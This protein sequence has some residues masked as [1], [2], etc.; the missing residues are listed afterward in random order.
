MLLRVLG[1]VQHRHSRKRS[2]VRDV[3]FGQDPFGRHPCCRSYAYDE[4]GIVA[5]R[6]SSQHLER[7]ESSRALSSG[8]NRV[9]RV[10]LFRMSRPSPMMVA[11]LF[12][13]PPIGSGTRTR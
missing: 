7:M 12:F 6:V 11:N 10:A 2:S 5:D 1:R 4:P 13:R 8:E 3:C 9:A